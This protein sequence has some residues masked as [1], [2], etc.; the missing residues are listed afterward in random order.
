M[1]YKIKPK[2]FNPQFTSVGC[3][4]EYQ[5]S[6]LLL[7]RQDYKPQGNTWGLPSGKVEK[8]ESINEGILRE[9]KEET[10]LDLALNSISNV[11][12]VYVRYNEYD[13]LYDIFYSKVEILP[14]VII[15]K[16]EHKA[17][18]WI[19]PKDALKMNL[20]EDLDACIKLY[21]E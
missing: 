10:G 8:G 20:I 9:I 16:K 2:N 11:L 19:K 21:Y 6:I 14:E 4:I 17:Y 13:F 15:N 12:E 18:K 1:I 3:F 5:D 7:H